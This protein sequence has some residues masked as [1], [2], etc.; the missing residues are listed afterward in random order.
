MGTKK[1]SS[2]ALKILLNKQKIAT[3]TELKRALGTDVERTIYRKLNELGYQSSYSHSGKYYTLEEIAQFNEYGLWFYKG[4][5]FSQHGTLIETIV[6]FVSNSE[7]GY[8][9]NELETILKV[10]V[11]ESLLVLLEKEKLYRKKLSKVYLYFSIDPKIQR[12]QILFRQDLELGK[13][14]SPDRVAT[15]LFSTLLDEKQRRL[16]AGL[17]AIKLG[18][19]GNKEVAD[20]LGL[21][22]H[23]VAKGKQEL[24]ERQYKE[25]GIR[26]VGGGRV[27]IKKKSTHY[28]KT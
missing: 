6:S 10:P 4:V 13:A 18:Y 5:S 2:E 28:N 20:N 27:P 7:N 12:R 25:E 11:K 22:V 17:E 8:S 9:A 24:L 1:Y 16:Y 23:T 15:I 21:D 3:L 26:E 14:S 19:G